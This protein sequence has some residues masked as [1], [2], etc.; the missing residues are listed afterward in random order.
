MR[1]KNLDL[2]IAEI[3][4]VLNIVWA[5]QPNHP[6]WTSFIGI[7]L[8]LPL[9]FIL[10]GY[11]LIG[12]IFHQRTLI[13]SHRL[14]LSIGLSLALDILSGFLLNVLPGGV[15]AFSWAV[16]LGLLTTVFALFVAYFRRGGQLQGTR[17]IR[18]RFNIS[19]YLLLSLAI[20]VAV[21]SVMYSLVGAEQ[22]PRPGFT[23]LW[24]L[25]ATQPDNSCAVRL[26]VRSFEATSVNYRVT[27]T[28]NG[29]PLHTWSLVVLTPEQTWH[30]L[31][32]VSPG[33]AH[34]MYIDVRLY[35][36][37][38]PQSVYR[39]VHLTLYNA[40]GSTQK[41]TQSKECSAT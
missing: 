27:M 14:I 12:A 16:L 37:D 26:G 2:L 13:A 18:L 23:Q 34:S 1:L 5:L 39:N 21:L 22:Q 35:R 9:I 38:Q 7:T 33:T 31:V 6:A 28:M 30:Q 3:I 15:Q 20:A 8:A 19:G 41:S 11:M 32:L 29:N 4:A 40:A 25:P 10:P 24:I 17:P 36:L